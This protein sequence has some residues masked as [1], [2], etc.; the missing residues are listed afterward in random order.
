MQAMPIDPG[1][2]GPAYQAAMTLQDA[3]N[4]INYYIEVAE[5]EGAKKPVALL[6]TPGLA[7]ACST[8]PLTVRGLWVLPG[9]AQALAV[10]GSQLFLITIKT[11][12]TALSQAVITATYI[13]GS[14]LNTS[15]GSVAIRD[16]GVLENGLG[17]YALISDGPYL[18]Y[19]LLSGANYSFTF[20]AAYQSGSP[21]LTLPGEVPNGLVITSG[22]TLTAVTGNI[23]PTTTII[24]VNTIPDPNVTITMSASASGTSA[25][26]TLTLSIPVFGQITDPGFLGTTRIMFIE[27]WLG[28]NQ[29]GTRTIYTTGPTPYQLLFPGL[30]YSLKDSSTDNAITHQENNREWW[31]IGERTTEVWYNAGN[32]IFSFSRVPGV[33]PQIGCSAPFSLTRM[34]LSLVW[35]GKNEQGENVVVQSVQYNWQRISN[36]AVETA[37]ASYTVISDAIG[38]AYEEAG[39]LFYV[40]TFPTADTTWVYDGTASQQLGKPC[41]HQRDSFD[42]GNGLYHRHRGNCYMDFADMR[43]VGDYQN[44]QLMQMS[45]SYYTEVG[46]PL[47]AQR[48]SKH[49]WKPDARTRVAQSSLQIEFTPG[50]GLG[51]TPGV[52]QG[53]N[54]QAM[55]RWSDDGGFTWSHE[56]WRSIGIQ[57]AYKNRAKWNRLGRARDRVYEISFSDPVPR[58]II[59]ATLYVEM[60][61]S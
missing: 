11:P 24:N 52:T 12:A 53:Q 40:I 2:V 37:I 47:R 30:F 49:V 18:Y 3:E 16:N 33:G 29:P 8:S 36:H 59:G 54:P 51:G 27:G 21:T 46:N 34:G 42:P 20:T 43:I 48:R 13:A 26:D 58:D 7:Q 45:R 56:H 44:G 60:E 55:L 31:V 39:H 25:A 61:E 32:A 23:P 9:G 10:V 14:T 5:V 57:G 1:I 19:Y 6:G 15:T 4:A 22:G 35:L 28:F 17:G 38:Y 41:W 50:V